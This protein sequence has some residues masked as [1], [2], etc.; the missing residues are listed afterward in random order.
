M[1]GPIVLSVRTETISSQDHFRIMLRTRYGTIHKILP[2]NGRI[3]TNF[4]N[5]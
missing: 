4:S 2:A 3:F 5:F 1:L